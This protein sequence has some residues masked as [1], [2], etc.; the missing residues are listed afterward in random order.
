MMGKSHQPKNWKD[1]SKRYILTY[2]LHDLS[3]C[4]R[5]KY[6]SIFRQFTLN[7]IYFSQVTFG[8]KHFSD[9]ITKRKLE[10]LPDNG[11]IV[12][13]SIA[14]IHKGKFEFIYISNDEMTG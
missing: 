3:F 13:E 7:L 4:S 12:F 2:E 14:N 8:L 9:V 10:M 6:F 1:L 5:M 11:T